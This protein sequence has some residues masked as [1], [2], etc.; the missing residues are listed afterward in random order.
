VLCQTTRSA[1]VLMHERQHKDG[2]SRIQWRKHIGLP[3]LSLHAL[4][5]AANRTI[6][7]FHGA[8]S[9]FAS[10]TEGRGSDK[11][12]ARARIGMVGVCASVLCDPMWMHSSCSDRARNAMRAY[13]MRSVPTTCQNYAFGREMWGRAVLEMR[14]RCQ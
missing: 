10:G 7:F 6:G 12:Y 9:C 5:T 4:S 3:N 14:D 13:D 8:Q 2:Q 11:A 1:C